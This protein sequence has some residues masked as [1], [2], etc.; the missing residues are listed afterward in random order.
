M[1]AKWNWGATMGVVFVC[2]IAIAL[3]GML[4]PTSMRFVIWIATLI[5]ITLLS[6]I[7]GKGMTGQWLG[8]L[9]DNRNKMSLSR[10]QIALWTILILSSLLTAA[11]TNLHIDI[12]TNSIDALS[13]NIPPELLA[14]MGISV[15]SLAASQLILSAKSNS[16]QEVDT[17]KTR[18]EA[19]WSDMFKGDDAANADYLDLG[20][21]QMLYITIILVLV[22]GVALAM[23]FMKVDPKNQTITAFT[24][25]PPLSATIV[26]LLGVSHAGY[27]TYKAVPRPSQTPPK[28]AEPSVT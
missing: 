12:L 22:Y 10:F 2:F 26:T 8:L 23:L 24:T 21:V 13:I 28:K 1:A 3:L 6:V 9:I 17:N 14:L 11:L 15:T 19:N 18:Q 5:F 27:L 4:L 7:L 25:F 20:K 16:N